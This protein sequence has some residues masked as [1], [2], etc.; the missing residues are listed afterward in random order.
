[1]R[2]RALEAQK[3]LAWCIS[4]SKWWPIYLCIMYIYIYGCRVY[5]YIAG[6]YCTN[7]CLTLQ[8]TVCY[9]KLP[10]EI[11]DFGLK[12]VISH[13]KLLVY[14]RV[15]YPSTGLGHY[16]PITSPL[17]P[18]YITIVLGAKDVDPNPS[19]PRSHRSLQRAA[20]CGR[21]GWRPH[22]K[23]AHP[24]EGKIGTNAAGK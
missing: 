8:Q 7:H 14:Q 24:P 23:C 16:I 5:I 19:H 20:R 6:L 17:F 11:E 1:M 15:L 21:S 22:E 2:Q 9:G 13:G 10:I 18:L 3:T 12:M 4:V